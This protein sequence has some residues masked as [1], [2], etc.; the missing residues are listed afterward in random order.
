[1]TG[2]VTRTADPLE[3]DRATP[4]AVAWPRWVAGLCVAFAVTAALVDTACM[5]LRGHLVTEFGV[6]DHGWPIIPLTGVVSTVMGALVVTRDRRQP[7]GWL[8]LVPGV[9]TTLALA[10]DAYSGWVLLDAGPGPMV[11]AVVCS[12]LASFLG[13]Q[14]P[15][16]A[17]AVILLLAPDGRLIGRTRG[18]AVVA[19]VAGC[20]LWSAPT[21][22]EAAVYAQT[23]P[24]PSALGQ[25]LF[26]AG[27]VLVDAAVLAGVVSLFVRRRREHAVARVQIQWFVVAAVP[28]AGSIVWLLL[29]GYVLHWPRS[30]ATHLPLFLAELVFP[31]AIAVAVL[32]YRLYDITVVLN[33][34]WLLLGTTAVVGTA[35]VLLVGTI[36]GS[37]PGFWPAV[38]A[39]A[40]VACLFQPI[41]SRIVAVADRLAYGDRLEPYEAL[42]ELVRRLGESAGADAT[43]AEIAAA[44]RRATGAEAVTIELYGESGDPVAVARDGAGPAGSPPAHHLRITDGRTTLG[45]IRVVPAPGRPLRRRDRVAL[46]DLSAQAGLVFRNLRLEAGRQARIEELARIGEQLRASHDRLAAARAQELRRL[47]LTVRESISPILQRLGEGLTA[48]AGAPPSS[49]DGR[50]NELSDE[51]GHC[52]AALRA[53]SHGVHSDVLDSL[54]LPAALAARL[55]QAGS[56]ARLTVAG[57]LSRQPPSP[58]VA[59]AVERCVMQALMIAPRLSDVTVTVAGHELVLA[60]VH[61]GSTEVPVVLGD[62]AESVG[63]RVR[64]GDTGWLLHFP[65]P[66]GLIERRADE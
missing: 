10:L 47:E 41:R 25:I 33:R 43:L 45:L 17:N 50:W 24:R 5:A 1:M 15:F 8:L 19:A 37:L 53:L 6:I 23:E 55:R 34:A 49:R 22:L 4:A 57:D 26:V 14:I 20:L 59:A 3:V 58:A 35:Y 12:W 7:I 39:S 62:L 29:T 64:G 21:V 11:V 16:A 61:P 28:F 48:L 32:R 54:G 30:A 9:T 36:G 38:L 44:G 18:L 42:A 2:P 52:L 27:L 46:A 65:L 31:L 51:V 13:A 60:L 63:G 40:V 66:G 56:G